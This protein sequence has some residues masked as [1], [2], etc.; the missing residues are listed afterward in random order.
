MPRVHPC[1]NAAPAD[2]PITGHGFDE[3]V[4][5]VW[6]L[7]QYNSGMAKKQ[8]KM[9][10]PPKT[11][12]VPMGRVFQMRLTTADLDHFRLASAKAGIPLAEWIRDR[13][14]RAAEA[15]VKRR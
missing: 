4:S 6:N 15:E 8:T 14:N 3:L 13:L 2:R 1:P 12:G 9:G 11:P 7:C 5:Q 10:R